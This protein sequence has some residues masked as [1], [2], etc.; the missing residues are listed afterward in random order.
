VKSIEGHKSFTL[1][2][3]GTLIAFAFITFYLALELK[4]TADYLGEKTLENVAAIDQV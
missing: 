3:W 1:I 2:A 4:Q